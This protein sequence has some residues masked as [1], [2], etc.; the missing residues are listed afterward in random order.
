MYIASF[1]PRLDPYPK[2]NEASSPNAWPVLMRKS[3]GA[4]FSE[5][6]KMRVA[7]LMPPLKAENNRLLADERQRFGQSE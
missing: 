6:R 2:A 7:L 5:V 3:S 4:L 1:C